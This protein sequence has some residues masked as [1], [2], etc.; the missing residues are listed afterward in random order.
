MLPTWVGTVAHQLEIVPLLGVLIVRP[1]ERSWYWL[2]LVYAVSWLAD[3]PW[4]FGVQWTY[5]SA[6]YP[7]VQS[8]LVA[9][10]LMTR[11]GALEWLV[12]LTALGLFARAIQPPEQ[13][14][15]LVHLVAWSAIA[16]MVSDAAVPFRRALRVTF[17]LG[18]LGWLGY[19]A[20]PGA[21]TWLV[22][23]AI[24]TLGEGLFC[25][26]LVRPQASV[27]VA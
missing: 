9:A 13:P 22:Y 7:I 25:W 20:F 18:L 16:L 1:K 19:V 15:W 10:V 8:A 24:W 27:R 3:W 17:G 23:K 21:V 6:V 11:R 12:A 4:Y 26:A 2:G 14:E 5:A